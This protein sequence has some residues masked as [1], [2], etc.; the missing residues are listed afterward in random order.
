MTDE[1]Q[2]LVVEDEAITGMDIQ[3][4][5]KNLGYIVP[6]VVSS[7]EEAINKAK[8]NNPDLILMDINLNGKMDGIEAAFKIHTFC[9]IPIIYLTAYT[10]EKTFERAQI[11]VPYAYIVKP[12]KDRELQ[13]TLEIA[14]YRKRMEKV[15]KES[16]QRLRRSK[17]WL[18]AAIKSMGDA[19]IA[20]DQNGIIE[21]INPMAQELTGWKEEDAVGKNLSDVFNIVSAETGKHAGDPVKKVIKDGMFNGLEKNTILMTKTGSKIPVYIKGRPITDEGYV[22]GI[23]IVFYNIDQN[24]ASLTSLL[25]CKDR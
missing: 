23:V 1:K 5:L 19:F 3:R 2:I 6:V 11:N 18:S 7:G 16:Y 21:L 14:F 4:R 20:T 25:Y 13:I 24:I 10:D 17:E 9:D 22:I 12:F 15:V 8:K